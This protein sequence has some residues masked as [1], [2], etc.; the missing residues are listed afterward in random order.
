MEEEKNINKQVVY[1]TVCGCANSRD[2]PNGS[3]M[4]NMTDGNLFDGNGLFES[5]AV[6]FV[7]C[8][9]SAF[10]PSHYVRKETAA[11]I[12]TARGICSMCHQSNGFCLGCAK[13]TAHRTH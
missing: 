11:A 4:K 13:Q 5:G 9:V 6:V 12:G 3:E 7:C 1:G 8:N 10:S 2:Q